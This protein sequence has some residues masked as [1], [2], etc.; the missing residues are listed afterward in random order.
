MEG[1]KDVSPM[2]E[3]KNPRRGDPM[4]RLKKPNISMRDVK[5]DGFLVVQLEDPDPEFPE[6]DIYLTAVLRSD[7]DDRNNLDATVDAL[8]QDVS[9]AIKKVTQAGEA[10]VGIKIRFGTKDTAGVVIAVV[11]HERLM[12]VLVREIESSG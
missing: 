7:E 6:Q 11:L 5:M 8:F 10:V 1:K 4:R 9:E 3:I 2:R 12:N